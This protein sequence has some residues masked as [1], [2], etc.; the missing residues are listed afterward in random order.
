MSLPNHQNPNKYKSHRAPLF[1]SLYFTIPNTH[2][3]YFY[4]KI[5]SIQNTHLLI[6]HYYFIADDFGNVFRDSVFV[7]I[8]TSFQ[9]AFEINRASFGQVFFG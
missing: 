3:T 9:L 7:L 4:T 5:A 6:E 1:L 2:C 8:R